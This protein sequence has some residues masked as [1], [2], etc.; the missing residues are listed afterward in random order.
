M[1][2]HRVRFATRG[3]YE[4]VRRVEELSG[5]G[6]GALLASG[7]SPEEWVLCTDS[8]VLSFPRFVGI[9]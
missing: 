9:Y 1:A 8:G 2:N 7:D 6:V 5:T 3:R 4:V